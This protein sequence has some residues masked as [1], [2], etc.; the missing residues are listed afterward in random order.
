MRRVEMD[1]E[2]RVQFER[3]RL[4]RLKQRIER[5]GAPSDERPK[6]DIHPLTADEID[7][8]IIAVRDAHHE[9]ISEL[10]VRMTAHAIDTSASEF[11]TALKKLGAEIADLRAA[12]AELRAVFF[13]EKAEKSAPVDLPKLPLRPRG[14]N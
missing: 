7:A 1:E 8:R 9:H 10:L 12:I 5:R 3:K 4:E 13:T 6:L 14:L 2:T 11:Q